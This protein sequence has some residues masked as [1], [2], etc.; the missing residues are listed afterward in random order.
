MNSMKLSAH[1]D[2]DAVTAPVVVKPLYPYGLR[3]SLESEQLG[4]LKAL[5]DVQVGNV[6]EVTA[7]AR[8]VGFSVNEDGDGK[9]RRLELQIEAMECSRDAK[10]EFSSGFKGK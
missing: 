4:K 8:V 5:D 6:V 10:H 1:A 9:N 2:K 7:K 3:L